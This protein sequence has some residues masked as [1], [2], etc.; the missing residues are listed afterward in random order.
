MVNIGGL[1]AA[2]RF[3]GRVWLCVRLLVGCLVGVL[4]CWVLMLLIGCDL[5]GCGWE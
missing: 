2:A 3:V 4:V 1:I 5:S